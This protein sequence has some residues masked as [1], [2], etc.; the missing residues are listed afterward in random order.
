MSVCVRVCGSVVC[1]S[2][3]CTVAKWLNGSGCRLGGNAVGLG[4]GV[5]DGVV[6]DE[7]EMAVLG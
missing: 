4:V 5:L 2:G 7:V 1:M 6:I 3:E